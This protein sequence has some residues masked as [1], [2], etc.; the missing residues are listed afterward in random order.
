MWQLLY[1]QLLNI[2]VGYYL[3]F[4]NLKFSFIY[5]LIPQITHQPSLRYPFLLYSMT[6]SISF[7]LLT[8]LFSYPASNLFSPLGFTHSINHHIFHITQTFFPP[9]AINIAAQNIPWLDIVDT[10]LVS[11]VVLAT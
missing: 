10:K 4:I 3:Y 11:L 1:F 9:I 7:Q 6:P 2:R 5:Y 8:S